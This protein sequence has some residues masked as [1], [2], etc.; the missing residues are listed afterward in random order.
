MLETV[1]SL[2]NCRDHATGRNALHVALTS[3]E[4]VYNRNHRIRLDVV[5]TLLYHWVDPTS[6]DPLS[7]RSVGE[8]VDILFGHRTDKLGD[9]LKACPLARQRRTCGATSSNIAATGD[10][11]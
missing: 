7:Q 5:K 11:R 2:A 8:L 6:V 3:L 4:T 10:A 1:P 9:L